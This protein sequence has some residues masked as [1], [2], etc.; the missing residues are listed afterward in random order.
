[1][2][3]LSARRTIAGRPLFHHVRCAFFRGRLTQ[4][5][6]SIVVIRRRFF[7][8]DISERLAARNIGRLREL[9]HRCSAGNSEQ[10]AAGEKRERASAIPLPMAIISFVHEPTS[11]QRPRPTKT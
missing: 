5:D 8:C 2:I 3:N 1:M 6:D 9:S 11:V 7:Q 4:R 10:H